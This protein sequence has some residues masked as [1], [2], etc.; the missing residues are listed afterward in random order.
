M[1]VSKLYSSL[2]VITLVLLAVTVLFQLLEM[3]EYTLFET[4][5]AR[6]FN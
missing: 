6:F 5:Q 3:N 4:L 2:L 1:S